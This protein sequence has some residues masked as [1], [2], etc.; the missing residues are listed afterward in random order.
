MQHNE[1]YGMLAELVCKD[2]FILLHFI[3]LYW[4][5]KEK[6]RQTWKFAV[7]APW[8]SVPLMWTWAH[9]KRNV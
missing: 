6:L 9:M 1:G 4:I 3:L 7:E 5:W 8:F 2:C